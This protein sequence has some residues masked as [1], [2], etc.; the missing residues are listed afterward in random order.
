[1]DIINEV[2]ALFKSTQS[3]RHHIEI[4][5]S[6][7]PDMLKKVFDKSPEIK[8]QYKSM[9]EDD[10]KV[11]VTKKPYD[12]WKEKNYEDDNPLLSCSEYMS[13]FLSKEQ[14]EGF[15]FE[16]FNDNSILTT[17]PVLIN[18]FV[19][20]MKRKNLNFTFDTKLKDLFKRHAKKL[21]IDMNSQISYSDL[22][23]LI[24]KGCTLSEDDKSINTK[25]EYLKIKELLNK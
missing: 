8:S 10:L 6:L 24:S 22:A 12:T 1:M 4:L 13:D 16:F 3:E 2:I 9:Y 19:L 14:L 20:Y 7:S 21:G 23:N 18:W 5:N 11:K 17:F 25:Q 15:E